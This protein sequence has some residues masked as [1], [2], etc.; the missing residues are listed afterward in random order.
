[1]QLQ[2]PSLERMWSSR[3]RPAGPSR[4]PSGSGRSFARAPELHEHVCWFVCLLACWLVCW[5]V[6]SFA[7]LF[8]VCLLAR[9]FVCADM[10]ARNPSIH[11]IR[12]SGHVLCCCV[13]SRDPAGNFWGGR[14]H[15]LIEWSMEDSVMPSPH[16]PTPRV[17]KETPPPLQFLIL[18][19]HLD[20]W[21]HRAVWSKITRLKLPA[22]GDGCCQG[23]VV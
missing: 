19:R 8:F 11:M 21:N 4:R 13:A 12:P 1:M 22:V 3:A 10:E 14:S 18:V 6:C 16:P 9:L 7:G 20:T 15:E 5:L 17:L 23:T 2:P